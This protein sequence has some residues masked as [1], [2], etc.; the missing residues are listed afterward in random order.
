MPLIESENYHF[1]GINSI[2]HSLIDSSFDRELSAHDGF[3]SKKNFK[4]FAFVVDVLCAAVLFSSFSIIKNH[5]NAPN[6]P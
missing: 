2:L 5:Q 6:N 3:R 1:Y 4:N